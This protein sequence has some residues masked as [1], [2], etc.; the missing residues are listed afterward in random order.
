MP[1]LNIQMNL[2]T[3]CDK[4]K[5]NLSLQERLTWGFKLSLEIDLKKTKKTNPK[6]SFHK[7]IEA[8]VAHAALAST[9]VKGQFGLYNT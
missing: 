1:S 3:R 2:C 5:T 6:I 7:S 4:L 8:V 9:G